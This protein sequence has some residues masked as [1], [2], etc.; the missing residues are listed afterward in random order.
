M[1]EVFRSFAVRV[2]NELAIGPGLAYSSAMP[3]PI[4]ADFRQAIEDYIRANALPPEKFSHQPRIY[5]LARKIGEGM[6]FDDDVLHAGAWLHD[7]GVFTGHRPENLEELAA[8][9]NVAYA[10]RR[11]PELLRGFGFPE[12]KIE[13]VLDAIRS[14]QPQATPL[15][16]EGAL[17]RDA[18]ILEQLGAVGILRS[19]CKIGRDTRFAT[20]ADV[21]KLLNRNLAE[22]PGK[23]RFDVARKEAG[24]RVETLRAFLESAEA[25]G[26]AL[27]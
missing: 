1:K 12:E 15:N 3:D 14:H 25:E 22:L 2:N 9:D 6:T 24:A 7:L 23:L 11:S 21:L 19:V 18:D 20:F 17:L 10:V 4:R 27:L 5:R 16:I 8:W 13:A 26:G